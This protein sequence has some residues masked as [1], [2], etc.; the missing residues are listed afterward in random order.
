MIGRLSD[1]QLAVVDLDLVDF[2]Q[3][4][5]ERCP[6]TAAASF[7]FAEGWRAH[8]VLALA[9][10]IVDKL[11]AEP[12]AGDEAPVDRQLRLA[13]GAAAASAPMHGLLSGGAHG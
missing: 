6:R 10:R 2:L 3:W 9:G 8:Q 12:H 11:F 7:E 4:K 13:L 1:E 5:R